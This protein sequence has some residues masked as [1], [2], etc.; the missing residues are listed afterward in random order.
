VAWRNARTR[1]IAGGLAA[2]ALAIGAVATAQET[3]T[4]A[5]RYRIEQIAWMAGDWQGEAGP[6]AFSQ[7]VWAA[8]AGDCMMGMWRL[9]V[10]GR[11]KLFESLSITQE[12]GGPVMRLRHIGAD[13]VAWEERDTP[14]TLQLHEAGDGLVVFAG[15]GRSGALRI[16][17][18][19]TGAD[20]MT[21][22]VEKTE[23]TETFSFRRASP[24]RGEPMRASALAPADRP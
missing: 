23:G 20:A 5:G 10:A 13:G 19:L 14:L 11:V 1:F 8:P 12:A 4:A 9:V 15:P 2:F 21:V 3:G 17:Y 7:E 18:R 24:W 16:V 6:E 22:S